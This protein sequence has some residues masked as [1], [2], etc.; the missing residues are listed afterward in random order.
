MSSPSDSGELENVQIEKT[1]S[2]DDSP[3]V[4][5]DSPK[6][7]QEIV[8]DPWALDEETELAEAAAAENQ[9]QSETAE[10]VSK[11][12]ESS[13]RLASNLDN[14]LGFTN[15]L[16]ALGQTVQ[17]L[18]KKTHVSET[19]KSATGT[20]SGTLG[21]WFSTVDSKLNISSRTMELGSNIQQMVPTQEISE[22]FQSTTRAIQT[23]DESHGITKSAANTLA[24]GADLLTGIVATKKEEN[25]ENLNKKEELD[26]DGIPTSFQ[27]D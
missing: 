16:G 11:L 6:V 12:R 14:K 13:V 17:N 20:I 23:F 19:V 2:K 3:V 18:D 9:E 15:A 24:Q 25:N 8:K 10:A 1:P 7:D 26:S 22:G 5:E 21:N 27:K 4:A